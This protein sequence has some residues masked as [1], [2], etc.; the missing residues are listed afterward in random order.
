MADQRLR[1][2]VKYY[3]WLNTGYSLFECIEIA[4]IGE[5]RIHVTIE[6]APRK[7]GKL[8]VGREAVAGDSSAKFE[9]P[10][11]QPSTLE[12]GVAG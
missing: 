12:A 7:V 10:R 3:F 1:R 4:D 9:Q 8:G 2:Q 6:A 11:R 5:N